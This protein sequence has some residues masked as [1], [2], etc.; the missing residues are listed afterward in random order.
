M[1]LLPD[2]QHGKTVVSFTLVRFVIV[3][4]GKANN[5]DPITIP[6]PETE[7]SLLL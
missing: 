6:W 4:S 2:V 7:V 5:L 3:V 1:T